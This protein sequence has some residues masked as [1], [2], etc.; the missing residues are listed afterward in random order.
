MKKP[1]AS[2]FCLAFA[3]LLALGILPALSLAQNRSGIVGVW[4]GTLDPGA[5]PKKRIVVHISAAQDGSLSGTIDYPDQDTSGI[6]ITAITYKARAL[7]FESSSIPALYDGTMD[8]A[9]SQITGTWKQGVAPLSLVLQ[10][11]P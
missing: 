10:R 6:Q 8:D 9:N 11:T 3:L 2:S 5:Q 1:R 7:H 4:E